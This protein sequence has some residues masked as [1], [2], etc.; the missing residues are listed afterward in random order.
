MPMEN[1]MKV[2]LG[3]AISGFVLVTLLSGCGYF[4]KPQGAVAAAESK[5]P[6]FSL[7]D[8]NGQRVSLDG[9]LEKGSAMIVFYRGHW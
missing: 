1:D 2:R 4:V 8:Q 6:G 9:L 5:A 7:P 3:A